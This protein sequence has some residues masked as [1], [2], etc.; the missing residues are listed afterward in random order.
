MPNIIR[1]SVAC[2][3]C[4]ERSQFFRNLGFTV[5]G[6]KPLPG[7]P[8]QCEITMVDPQ[9]DEVAASA[10]GALAGLAAPV[11]DASDAE[12]PQHAEAAVDALEISPAGLMPSQLRAAQA[13][14]NIFE[15]GEVLGDYGQVTLLEGDSGHLTFGRSQTT[16]A[17]GNLGKLIERYVGNPAARW[18]ARL[19]GVLP[20]LRDADL[21]L[22]GDEKFKNL[23]RATADDPVMRE[24]QDAFFDDAYWLPAARA[25]ERLGIRLPLGVC[26]VYDSHVHG[27]WPLTRDRT[28]EAVGKP[29]TAGERQWLQ[30]YVALRHEWLAQHSNKL[31]RKTVYRMEAFKRLIELGAWGLELPLV[32][33]GCEISMATLNAVPPGCYDGPQPGT[34]TLALQSPLQKG[35]DVRLVQ[36]A[37]S[38]RGFDIRADGLFG[39][40]SRD[41]VAEFQAVRGLPVTG[42]LDTALIAQL[43]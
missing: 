9:F 16:L 4:E 42:V 10:S 6:C 31:L 20:R 35:L 11:A 36:L 30:R 34:R 2:A 41:R 38:D 12:A 23:L 19:V 5:L 21:S 37:L 3:K 8:Q 39:K 26:I 40:T 15:T 18:G 13:I 43:S 29:E 27:S 22:D 7:A 24:T 25:A 17:T 33:R 28:H 32:V 1:R 14:V